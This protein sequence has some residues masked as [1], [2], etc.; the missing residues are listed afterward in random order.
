MKQVLGGMRLAGGWLSCSEVFLSFFCNDRLVDRRKLQNWSRKINAE[1]LI[2]G[3]EASSS[4]LCR[5]IRS[6]IR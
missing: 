5:F 3:G 4:F 1:F 2:F 6:Q